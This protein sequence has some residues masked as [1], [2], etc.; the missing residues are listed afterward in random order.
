M[1]LVQQLFHVENWTR[2]LDTTF[3]FTYGRIFL[4]GR[5]FEQNKVYPQYLPTSSELTLTMAKPVL[6]YWDIRG[7][8]EPARLMFEFLEIPYEDKRYV[9]G[10]APN[11]DRSCW[12]DIKPTLGLP[13]PNLP[14][15]I[16][17]ET[18]LTESS[19]ILK[20][21]ARMK[22]GLMPS[23]PTEEDRCNVF[24]GVVSDF[25][26]NFTTICYRQDH[27]ANKANFFDNIF[28]RKMKLFNDY[29]EGKTWAAGDT[30]TYVDFAFA[31]ILDHIRLMQPDCFEKYENVAKYLEN[32]FKLEKINV[33]RQSSRFKKFPINN[34]MAHWGGKAE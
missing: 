17:G 13:F 21:I 3:H 11:Y 23:N 32:F 18:K 26:S 20:H 6:G 7:L 14:Y 10:D 24:E 25:R 8:A 22:P 33:Y 16:D 34:K 15:F 28:P 5:I 30:L 27:D 19:A 29:L 2:A 4:N 9:C 31:E 12:L 1:L